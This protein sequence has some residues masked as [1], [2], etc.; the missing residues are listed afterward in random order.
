MC[1]CISDTVTTILSS[2]MSLLLT[3]NVNAALT[4]QLFSQTFHFINMWLFNRLIRERQLCTREWGRRLRYWL[5]HIEVW[6]EKQGL[7]LAAE[8]HLGRII[9]VSALLNFSDYFNYFLWQS[10]SRIL[11]QIRKANVTVMHCLFQ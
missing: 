7:E 9:Q 2:I 3:T 1:V 4:I 8:C 6:S 5:G 10:C 11:F